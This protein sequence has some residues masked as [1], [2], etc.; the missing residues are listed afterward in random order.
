MP[1]SHRPKPT[2]NSE[3]PSAVYISSV[4]Q[5]RKLPVNSAINM[6]FIGLGVDPWTFIRESMRWVK[7]WFVGWGIWKDGGRE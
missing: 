4:A 7:T 3:E 2:T 6:E 5:S 1:P